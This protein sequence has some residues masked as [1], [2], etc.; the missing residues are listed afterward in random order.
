MISGQVKPSLQKQVCDR[1][2]KMVDVDVNKMLA[3]LPLKIPLSATRINP[4]DNSTSA[5]STARFL[6]RVERAVKGF[7][8]VDYPTSGSAK[9]SE[10]PISV[11]INEN[12]CY[13]LFV[14]TFKS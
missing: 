5:P 7:D 6:R 9:K 1:L 4:S 8:Y 12:V 13:Y 2:I 14:H 11:K 10:P 3:T